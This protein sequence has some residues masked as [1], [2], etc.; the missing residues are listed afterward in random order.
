M[1]K[2]ILNIF[3]AALSVILLY[4]CD[5]DTV[6]D[7]F[8]ADVPFYGQFLTPSGTLFTEENADNIFTSKVTLTAPLDQSVTFGIEVADD[9][10]AV[11]GVDFDLLT[12]EVTIPSGNIENTF[13]IQSFFE[14]ASFD[15]KIAKLNIVDL[16]P[17]D[18]ILI[19]GNSS[20]EINIIKSCPLEAE[21]LGD[22]TVS[23]V[24]APYAAAGVPIFE[25]TVT[26]TEGSNQFQ[27]I[28]EAKFYAA[29]GFAN[30]PVPVAFE[31]V[32]GNV[33]MI[34]ETEP[35]GL[36]CG[37]SISVGPTTDTPSTFD[38]ADDSQIEITFFE[39]DTNNCDVGQQTTIVLTKVQ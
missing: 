1:K 32:C 13:Q 26:L 6:D 36:G 35:S 2:N 11:E 18:N 28:F 24:T 7:G 27:R 17:N 21:F 12:T 31:L 9:S 39:D 3:Y 25:G 30:P 5:P 19:Q 23:Q 4:G 33:N 22:Y 14:T 16:N 38:E 20:I 15:G 37:G 34:G 10:D 29:L 8:F